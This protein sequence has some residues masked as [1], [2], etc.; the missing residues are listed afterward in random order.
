[1]TT[2]FD[3]LSLWA[4]LRVQESLFAV[5]CDTV[6]SII[7]LAEVTAVPNLPKYMRGIIRYQGK[8]ISLVDLRSLLNIPS[9]ASEVRDFAALMDA[10]EQDHINWLNTLQ[11]CVNSGTRFTL[12]TDPRQCKFGQWYYKTLPEIKDATLKTILENFERPHNAIHS[13][14]IKVEQLLAKHEADQASEL[15]KRKKNHELQRMINLFGEVKKVYRDHHQEIAVI[16]ES[17]VI[18]S[19]IVD[20]VVSIANLSWEHWQ[21][22]EEMLSGAQNLQL[23]LGIAE[24]LESNAPVMILNLPNVYNPQYNSI[25]Q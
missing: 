16:L 25:R 1:M 10:R 9:I 6:Q 12:A 11:E 21:P 22:V 4:V 15:I 3:P 17:D 13:I 2:A 8:P 7:T 19:L 18:F 20:E 24:M 14:A 5:P 23:I